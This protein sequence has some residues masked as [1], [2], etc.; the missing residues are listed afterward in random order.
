MPAAMASPCRSLL[1]LTLL[2]LLLF[3]SRLLHIFR[4]DASRLGSFLG[5]LLLGRLGVV[6]LLLG[7]LDPIVDYGMSAALPS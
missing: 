3:L 5:L 7:I 1:L 4:L 6:Q 2:I